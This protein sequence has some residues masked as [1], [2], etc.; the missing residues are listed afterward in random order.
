MGGQ[1]GR[2]AAVT[3]QAVAGPARRCCGLLLTRDARIALWRLT[4]WRLGSIWGAGTTQSA[5]AGAVATWL[6][7]ADGA[8][9]GSCCV[10]L[11]GVDV[12]TGR[13]RPLKPCCHGATLIT[14]SHTRGRANA[15]TAARGV[16]G[17]DTPRVEGLDT[18]HLRCLPVSQHN[19][20]S[21]PAHQILVPAGA[22]AH[23]YDE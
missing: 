5:L 17:R 11:A 22:A 18:Q 1:Q 23:F 3:G 14:G 16:C 20:N 13:F 7:G 10:D 12:T 19:S 4:D 6:T 21:P 15:L 2:S 9:V 8:C